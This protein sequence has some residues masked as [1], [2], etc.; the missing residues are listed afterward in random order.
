[1]SRRPRLPD[2]F[3]LRE[4]ET[5]GSTND[6]AKRMATEEGAPDGMVIWAHEQTAGKGRRAR[7]WVSKPGNLYSSVLLRPN[8]SAEC[9]GQIGFLTCL[10]VY[11]AVA[12]HAGGKA[13]IHCK[14]PNDVLLNG[15]KISG[16]LIEAASLPNAKLDWL[17]IGCGINLIHY[18]GD[19]NYPATSVLEECGSAPTVAEM[20]E[21]YTQTLCDWLRIWQTSGFAPV[22]QAWLNRAS[23]LGEKI[24]VQLDKE[25]LEGIFSKMDDDG[26]LILDTANGVRKITTGDIYAPA[27]A[28]GE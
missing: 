7:N 1:M 23:G 21:N 2:Q 10:A 24:K 25:T 18:P 15:K 16:I 27:A 22:R 3:Q 12:Q 9:A 13:D 14:W 4:L 20:L 8:I 26:A 11:D 5:V 17:V 28:I 6:E 19:T